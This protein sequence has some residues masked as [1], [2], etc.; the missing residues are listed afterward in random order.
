M[1]PGLAPIRWLVVY[2]GASFVGAVMAANVVKYTAR[3]FFK[4]RF[5]GTRKTLFSS[6]RGRQQEEPS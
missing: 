3:S 5:R 1:I 4:S 2:F 6:S